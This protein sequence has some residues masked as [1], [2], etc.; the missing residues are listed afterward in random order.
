VPVRDAVIDWVGSC[1]AATLAVSLRDGVGVGVEDT[2]DV[3]VMV[4]EIVGVTY[5]ET[6]TVSV[7]IEAAST[8]PPTR[9]ASGWVGG[10]DTVPVALKAKLWEVDM[11]AVAM[12]ETDPLGDIEGGAVGGM[13]VV[14]V[15]LTERLFEAVLDAVALTDALPV[16]VGELVHENVRD[17]VT[18]TEGVGKQL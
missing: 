4:E 9:G 10:I 13:V 12:S 17:G 7:E 16:F 8:L 5:E 15:G 6:E 14:L 3:V 18:V 1:D 2:V 11:V